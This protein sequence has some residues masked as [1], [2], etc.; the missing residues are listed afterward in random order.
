MTAIVVFL[1]LIVFLLTLTVLLK[2]QTNDRQI[3]GYKLSAKPLVVM[4]MLM[5]IFG[6]FVSVNFFVGSESLPDGV[7]RCRAI[8]GLILLA[9]VSFGEAF[10]RV[11]ASTIWFL[12][13]AFF[14]VT[15]VWVMRKISK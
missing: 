14:L 10:A 5:G 2:E 6:L 3:L 1:G 13:G 7:G 15:A 9:K 11:F 4:F 12:L 8:C